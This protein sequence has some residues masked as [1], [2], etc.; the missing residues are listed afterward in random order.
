M[1]YKIFSFAG[2]QTGMIAA[3]GVVVM[4][5]FVVIIAVLIKV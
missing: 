4:I 3:G 5:I 1:M 2:A